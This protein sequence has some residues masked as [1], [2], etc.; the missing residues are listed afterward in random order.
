MHAS[1]CSS[2]LADFYNWKKAGA[3]G[4]HTAV[5]MTGVHILPGL[6]SARCV[7]RAAGPFPGCVPPKCSRFQA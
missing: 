7:L 4:K 3:D 1:L 2:F 5:R 6:L